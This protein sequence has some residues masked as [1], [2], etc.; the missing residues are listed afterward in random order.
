MSKPEY[1]TNTYYTTDKDSG[2]RIKHEVKYRID[3]D[4][5]P[6]SI[7]DICKE[8]IENYCVANNATDWLVEAVD[9]TDANGK[10]VHFNVVRSDFVDKFFPQLRDKNKKQVKNIPW[11]QKMKEKYGKK[12]QEAK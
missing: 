7:R 10:P 2:E 5:K 4:F 11:G 3:A 12:S 8:F 1:L 6:T 9:K